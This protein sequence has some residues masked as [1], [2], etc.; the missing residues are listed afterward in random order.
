MAAF[1]GVASYLQQQKNS[2]QHV[3]NEAIKQV[4]VTGDWTAVQALEL[5]EIKDLNTVAEAKTKQLKGVR[6]EQIKYQQTV[7]TF[8][9]RTWSVPKWFVS[10]LW[11]STAHY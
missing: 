11:G 3:F 8:N 7:G 1:D 10:R 5:Q 6:G 9:E 4:A 2:L